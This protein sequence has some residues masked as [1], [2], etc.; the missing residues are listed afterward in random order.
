MTRQV[1]IPALVALGLAFLEIERGVRELESIVGAQ[2][3]DGLYAGEDG[4][5][6]LPLL[7]LDQGAQIL[8][9]R[10]LRV[11][12]RDRGQDRCRQYFFHD[13]SPH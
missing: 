13:F 12:R 11:R 5:L 1:G 10:R 7:G 4:G 8:I 6:D 9:V 3:P 2:R